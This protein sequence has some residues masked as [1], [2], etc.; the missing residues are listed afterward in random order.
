MNVEIG[1]VAAQFLFWEYLFQIFGIGSLQRFRLNKRIRTSLHGGRLDFSFSQKW[2]KLGILLQK[3][4][5]EIEM[6]KKSQ[7]SDNRP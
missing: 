3:D 6:K 4:A 7:F 1:I 2:R 5:N